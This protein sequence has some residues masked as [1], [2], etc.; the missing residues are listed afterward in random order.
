[1]E[2]NEKLYQQ[3]A[4]AKLREI[5]ARIEELKA[6][7]E[8]VRADVRLELNRQIEGIKS[9]KARLQS[10]LAEM[11]GA[12]ADAFGDLKAGTD[13]AIADLKTAI[14]RAVDRFM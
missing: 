14:D 4:E 12:G 9:E 1:M 3:K 8:Q 2:G 5:T 11:K 7:S 10:K 6:K 13:R